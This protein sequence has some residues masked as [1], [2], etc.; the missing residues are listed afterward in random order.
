MQAHE[1]I[2]K[3][4]GKPV[5]DLITGFKGVVSSIA[6]DAYGCIQAIVQPPVAKDGS[7]PDSRWFDVARLKITNQKR[8][9][10]LPNFVQ[11]YVAEGRKGPAEKPAK[12]H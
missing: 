5:Q 11:G 8:V 3:Y 2:E 12:E 1:Q 7:V 4:L 10:Q 6:F 9:L